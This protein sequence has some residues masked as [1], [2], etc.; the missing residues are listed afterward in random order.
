MKKYNIYILL[1]SIMS[2]ASC[3]VSRDI[4]V[5][6]IKIAGTYRNIPVP[7]PPAPVEDSAGI[8]ALSWKDFFSEPDLR[9]LIDTAIRSNNDLQVALKNIESARLVQRQANLGNLPEINLQVSASSNR[10]SDNSLDGLSLSQYLK[11][12]HIE[13]YTAE[14]NLSWEADI[15]GKIRNQKREALAE[16]L[17]TS[18]AKKAIQT[19]I[20]ATISQGYYHLLVLDKQLAIAQKNLALNDSTLRVIHLQYDAGQ[21]TALAVQQ[22]TAQELVAAQLVPEIEQ[23][24]AVQENALSILM[25]KNPGSIIRN[26]ILDT[27]L[28]PSNIS[29]GIP[30]SMVSRRPDVKSY[31]LAL[32]IAN[33]KVGIAQAN[34]Y[35]ALNITAGGGLNTFQ[36]NNW[37]SIPASLF[38]TI[39]GG[40]TQPLFLRN[41]LK[42]QYKLA[43]IEREKAVIQFRQSVLHAVGE[44]SDAL[45]KIN[46]LKTQQEIA[47]NRVNT[48]EQAIANAGMLFKNGMANYLEV[49]TAQSNVLQSELDLADIKR[50]Q[51]NAVVDLYKSLGGGWQ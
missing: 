34:K 18:E 28:I 36:L 43:G 44:V 45:V 30:S 29:A 5:S 11:S 40:I 47:A 35:P 48:L 3:K 27:L 31:E 4:Q 10:P 33:A 2:L 22:A 32:T 39:A 26:T 23:D 51:L 21:V 49:I 13:D 12:K 15:W 38:G 42:T 24:I 14:V 46:K 37:F 41:Q 17:Q 1:L 6:E 16:Y 7:D 25:G 9:N 19:S 50:A 20:V 8:G